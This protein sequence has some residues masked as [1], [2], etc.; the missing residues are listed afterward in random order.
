[1]YKSFVPFSSN[2]ILR[3]DDFL[4]PL[5]E[6]ARSHVYVEDTGNKADSLHRRIKQVYVED[7]SFA[8][9]RVMTPLIKKL[10]LGSVLLAI[11]STTEDFYGEHAD[12]FLRGWT[13]ERGVQA[14]YHFAVLSLVGKQKVPLLAIPWDLSMT[15]ANMVKELLDF[16]KRLFNSVYCILLD[17]GFYS[18]A[19]IDCLQKE[20]YNYIIRAPVK[21]PMQ[22]M[23]N[24]TIDWQTWKHTIKWNNNKSDHKTTTNIVVV[25]HVQF[26][27]GTGNCCFATNM[28]LNKGMEYVH[29]YIKRWQIETNFRMQDQVSIKSK[30]VSI[31]IRYFYFLISMLLHAYWLL[32]HAKKIALDKFKIQ[33]ANQLLFTTVGITYCN[34]LI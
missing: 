24:E 16:A 15:H 3:P 31:E 18:G 19:V 34:P 29:L 27:K 10:R 28:K 12:L 5:V 30:S 25:K 13:G 7:F 17:A 4:Q 1:M 6:A 21:K 22:Q 32:H 14:R 2:S 8:C 20:K 11:D 23:I 33:L 9:Q 26:K